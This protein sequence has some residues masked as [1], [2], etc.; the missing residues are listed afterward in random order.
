MRVIKRDLT[1]VEVEFDEITRKIKKLANMEP[2]LN[3]DVGVL[4]REVISLIYDG[5]S[6][7]EL[8]EFTASTAANMSLYNS[9]YEKL[10]GRLII[11]NHIKNTSSSFKDSI[12]KLKYV[13]SDEIYDIYNKHS[14]T[15]ENLIVLDRDYNISY[16]GFCTLKKSYLL[17]NN[18]KTVERPQ[19]L[20]LR[21]ALGIHADDFK[22]VKETYDL[23][24]L[25]YCTHATPTLFNAGTKYPQMSSCYLIGT[26]DSVEGIYKTITDVAKISKW[27]G[28][29]GV[30]IS[31]IRACGSE[32]SKTHGESQGLI[33]MLKVYNDTARYI[34]QSSK[35]N[36]SFAMYLEP[37][38]ADIFPFLEAKKNNGAEE[39]RAR[40]LFYA[41]WIP[42]LFIKRVREHGKWSLMCPNQCPGLTE[43]HSEEFEILYEKYESEGKYVRQIDVLELWNIIINS[44]IETGM[45]YMCYKDAVNRK[46]NQKNI[47]II[48]SSNLCTEINEYSDS[49]ETAVC[50]L[51]SLCLPKFIDLKIGN[52]EVGNTDLGPQCFVKV[53]SKNDCSYCNLTKVLLKNNNI[54]F[55]EIL[56]ND[57]NERI[58]FYENYTDEESGVLVNTMPQIFINDERIGGYK[59]LLTQLHFDFNFVKLG[60]VVETLVDNLN[61]II[62]KNFYPTDESKLSNLKYRPIG[63]GV[64]GLAD[65]FMILKL[66]FASTEARKLNKDIFETIYFHSLKK[67]CE[68]SCEYGSYTN[69]EGSPASK[70][71][72]QFDMWDKV[73]ELISLECW[74]SLKNDIKEHGLRN[75]LLVAPMPTASTAQ[76]MGNN[77]SIEP[78]TSNIYSR[79]VLSGE[80]VLINKH[81]I[82][83]LKEINLMEKDV[84]DSIILA[85]GSVQNINIPQEAKEIFKTV[86]EISQKAL[87]EM[88]ADRGSYICQSQSLN[89]FIEKADPKIINS[90]HLYGH[91]LGLKTGSYYIRTKP[92]L[93]SQNFSMEHSVEQEN[94]S[95]TENNGKNKTNGKTENEEDEGCLMCSG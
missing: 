9:D 33:P 84:I 23:L 68:L 15:I 34:N 43:C 8:D 85:K 44:Q 88:S 51:A 76:I 27:A 45:P 87:L 92:V 93:S 64:Q 89:I 1:E 62:D 94:R 12:D 60:E 19:H 3:I 30:H 20:F 72:L 7:S 17:K 77:E 65:V 74:N 6:T 35:R 40:D 41:L 14:E 81:L 59:E 46:S 26:E 42:D 31:N 22:K 49:K 13:I 39:I 79:R 54:K 67:S 73:P 69:F 21:V 66:P 56:L 71:I 16:F 53:Y 11:N 80:F 5:I 95:K 48:K 55:E 32:I 90:V 37:W 29:I 24:S 91:S 83:Y 28:G 58:E 63:L 75:S 82:K 4:A 61:L 57:L 2:I 47:G 50:N 78:Y 36:G 70:G 18:N 38:H 10:A 52:Y 86:W 25:N